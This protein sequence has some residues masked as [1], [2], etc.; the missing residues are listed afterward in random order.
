MTLQETLT[1]L[2]DEISEKD[3]FKCEND[4]YKVYSDKQVWQRG[5]TSA[6]DLLLPLIEKMKGALEFY[7]NESSWVK[8]QGDGD[9]VIARGDNSYNESIHMYFGGKTAREALSE[10]KKLEE[11]LGK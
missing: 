6:Q 9:S 2:R 7:G 1:R 4:K 11:G 3:I 8:R 5:F 10:L